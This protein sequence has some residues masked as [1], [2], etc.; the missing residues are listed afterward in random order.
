M[1]SVGKPS[2]SSAVL[3][4][5][6]VMVVVDGRD[7]LLSFDRLLIIGLDGGVCDAMYC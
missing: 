4:V 5:V 7:S 1:V 3:S 2:V 6:V